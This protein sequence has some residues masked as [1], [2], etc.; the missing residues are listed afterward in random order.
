LDIILP[1]EYTGIQDRNNP[2]KSLQINLVSVIKSNNETKNKLNEINISKKTKKIKKIKNKNVKI[3]KFSSDKLL[4]HSVISLQLEDSKYRNNQDY[5]MSSIGSILDIIRQSTPSRVNNSSLLIYGK[6]TRYSA[7]NKNI[8]NMIRLD[9]KKKQTMKIR[10]P[11]NM[12]RIRLNAFS[13]KS[14]LSPVNKSRRLFETINTSDL[15][16]IKENEDYV[17]SSFDRGDTKEEDDEKDQFFMNRLY[18]NKDNTNT[19]IFNFEEE[20][21]VHKNRSFEL[22]RNFISNN[23]YKI[24]DLNDLEIKRNNSVKIKKKVDI[25]SFC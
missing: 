2:Q 3:K 14:L 23:L 11:N 21:E 25:F 10:I 20:E 6:D 7:E 15:L 19:N 18:S 5:N 17:V 1:Y 24:I 8:N 9:I 16:S 13:N 12:N 4:I 22:N